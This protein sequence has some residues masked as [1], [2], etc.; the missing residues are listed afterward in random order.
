MKKLKAVFIRYIIGYII[1]INLIGIN[2]TLMASPDCMDNS[3][4]LAKKLDFKEYHLVSEGKHA[5]HHNCYT[6]PHSTITNDRGYCTGCGHY[7]R[8]RPFIIVSQ[9]EKPSATPVTENQ[10][11]YK[12]S[13]HLIKKKNPAVLAHMLFN[14]KNQ[15]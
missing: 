15:Q 6:D 8:P 9:K 12:K 14:P 4:H 10:A 3:W 7:H 5:C 1:C 11:K 2:L 13:K